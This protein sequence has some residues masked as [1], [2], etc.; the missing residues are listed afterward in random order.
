MNKQV[1]FMDMDGVITDF[2][3]STLKLFGIEYKA[4]EWPKGQY[5]IDIAMKIDDSDMWD[6]INKCEGFW[7]NLPL[8][9][10][11]LELYNKLSEIGEVVFLTSPNRDPKGSSGKVAWLLDRFGIK[12]RNY[13]LTS[14]KHLC[15]G[16]GILIDDYDDKVDKFREAGGWSILYPQPWNSNHHLQDDRNGYV[17][18]EVNRILELIRKFDDELNSATIEVY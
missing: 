11:G 6:R 5:G 16:N 9:P 8:L 14:Q 15:A 1:F 17:M 18:G 10:E 12:F 7:E 13:I 3:G 4:N 2:V